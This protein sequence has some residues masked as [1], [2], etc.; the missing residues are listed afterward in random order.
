MYY[1]GTTRVQL[2]T[3]S[4]VLMRLCTQVLLSLWQST[5]ECVC[6]RPWGKRFHLELS[7]THWVLLRQRWWNTIFI[8]LSNIRTIISTSDFF[9][10]VQ[11]GMA[12]SINW[13]D[14]SWPSSSTLS[15]SWSRLVW[16]RCGMMFSWLELTC[17]E[18]T[19]DGRFKYISINNN[20]K[21]I[22]NNR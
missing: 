8:P 11:R 20:D 22:I 1:S 16:Y 12:Y 5:W 4:Q 18:V 3:Y 21:S 7:C 19:V 9:A 10:G 15:V 17:R 2:M 13:I 14:L 6:A